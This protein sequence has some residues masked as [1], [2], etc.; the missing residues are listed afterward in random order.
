ME[1][2]N[3]AIQLPDVHV[4]E[5]RGRGD[6]AAAIVEREPDLAEFVPQ[7]ARQQVWEENVVVIDDL[8]PWQTVETP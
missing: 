8:S 1:T 7:R 4:F 3:F 2:R 6:A 5:A